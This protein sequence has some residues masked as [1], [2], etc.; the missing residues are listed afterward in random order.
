MKIGILTFH[1][2]H[3]YGSMLQAYALQ[4]TLLGEGY[5]CDIIDF[6]TPAQG[7]LYSHPLKGSNV[8]K[9]TLK[10]LSLPF[11]SELRDRIKKYERFETFISQ[12]YK[13]SSKSF[14]RREELNN[15]D[16]DVIITGSDQIWNTGCV[17]FD[18]AYYVD[19]DYN[20]MRI[21]Y[22]VS[23]GP[24]R[25]NLLEKDRISRCVQLYDKVMVR[26]KGTSDKVMSICNVKST[27]TLDPTLLLQ[28]NKWEDLAG[29]EPLIPGDYIFCYSP[30]PKMEMFNL[31]KYLGE[32]TN[33][34]VVTSLPIPRTSFFDIF[35][36]QDILQ[37]YIAAGPI[38]FLN[39]MKYARFVISSSFH[40]VAFSHIFKI[41]FWAIDGMKDNRIRTLLINSNLE[42]R[43]NSTDYIKNH[44]QETY[45]VDFSVAEENLA[46]QAESSKQELFSQLK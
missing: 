1:R 18:W 5:S 41:P 3:N 19:F 43:G 46:K 23:M 2:S 13:L 33:M 12:R 26:E 34:K 21:A 40:A 6:A 32:K 36:K 44:W 25:D 28:T 37:Q 38:E 29:S 7:R 22:A 39:L 31:A 24:G 11:W 17:D 9:N 10:T 15:I 4:Q 35:K 30:V 45:D 42:K 8:I 16:Y 20:G 27:I 14:S